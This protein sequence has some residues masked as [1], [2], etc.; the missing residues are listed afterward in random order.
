MAAEP[1]V[2]IHGFSSI[3]EVWEPV[4]PALQEHHDVTNVTLLGHCRGAAFPDGVA[5]SFDALADGVERDMDAA[6][7]K[8]A[9][10]VGNSLG[11]WLALELAHRGRALSVV[12]VAPAGGWDP[13]SREERRLKPYF[14]RV[15][16]M[17]QFA[18]PRAEA[19]TKRPRLRRLVLR[20]AVSF[21][22]KVPPRAAAEIIRGSYECPAYLELLEAIADGGPA[23][24]LSGI[25]VPV[26][27]VWGTRDRIIP[28]ERYSPRLLRLVPSAELVRLEGLGHVPMSD[29]PEGVARAILDVTARASSTA[30]APA[31][32]S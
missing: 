19:L 3:A 14:K 2:L 6:G 10:L 27:I 24:D 17:V 22:E 15:H 31:T 23:T 20:D 28:V 30:Y 18:G 5:P 29:D 9:H 25:D 16:R 4:L 21:G 26:R 1:L 13:G 32:L 11:G 12:A 7:I 8:K